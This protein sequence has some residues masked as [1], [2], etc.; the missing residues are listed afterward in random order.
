MQY[1]HQLRKRRNVYPPAFIIRQHQVQFIKFVHGHQVNQTFDFL[2][3]PEVTNYVQ[4]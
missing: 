2:F 3:I 4:T 1:L